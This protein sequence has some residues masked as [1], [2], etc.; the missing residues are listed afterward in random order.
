M[1]LDRYID[2]YFYKNNYDS[3]AQKLNFPLITSLT[4]YSKSGINHQ[5]VIISLSIYQFP[6][7]NEKYMFLKNVKTDLRK[8]HPQE[9]ALLSICL[10]RMSGW[11]PLGPYQNSHS[12]RRLS[13]M[14]LFQVIKWNCE[15]GP[16]VKG[17]TLSS[18]EIKL[19]KMWYIYT[20]LHLTM[21][22][23]QTIT[24]QKWTKQN[25]QELK[26]EQSGL[27]KNLNSMKVKQ[28]VVWTIIYSDVNQLDDSQQEKYYIQLEKN[29]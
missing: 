16:P 23:L 4:F 13:R 9:L 20:I 17:I 11:T 1:I 8:G 19:N 18:Y 6:N 29:R 3:V 7:R 28:K 10:E 12:P 24:F 2:I 22:L 27:S 25:W 14:R 15:N 21:L 5:S 26:Y